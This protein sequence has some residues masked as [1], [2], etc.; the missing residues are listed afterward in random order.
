MLKYTDTLISQNSLDYST[1]KDRAEKVHQ[2]LFS[3][4][5][6]KSIF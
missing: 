2:N 1:V 4:K 6:K 5:E 3:L